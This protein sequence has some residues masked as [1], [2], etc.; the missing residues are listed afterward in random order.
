MISSH[1][2]F[3][4]LDSIFIPNLYAQA[5]NYEPL[6][7]DTSVTKG[8]ATLAKNQ[9]WDMVS[10]PLNVQPIGSKWVYIVTLN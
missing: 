7:K 1:L 5:N 2:L 4:S 10:N 9:T 6:E 3:A 8:L